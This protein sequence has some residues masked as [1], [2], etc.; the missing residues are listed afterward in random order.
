MPDPTAGLKHLMPPAPMPPAPK[1]SNAEVQKY[2][3]ASMK[4][5]EEN[6][7]SLEVYERRLL[8]KIKKASQAAQEAL[9]GAQDLKNQIAQAEARM[10]T[11]ELQT[12]SHQ[13]SVNA[14]VDEIVSMKFNIEESSVPTP[15]KPDVSAEAEGK[16]KK[17]L[18]AVKD[19]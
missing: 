10:R 13:G 8:G 17:G 5:L 4:K 1:P 3:D 6:P 18:K 2:I 19:D 11:L 7:A 16:V 15:P 12:E 14:Y 9:R